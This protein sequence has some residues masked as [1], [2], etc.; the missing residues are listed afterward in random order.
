MRC[1]SP[2]KTAEEWERR[3]KDSVKTI[4][5]TGASASPR[6]ASAWERPSSPSGSG[7]PSR[8]R[9]VGTTSMFWDKVSTRRPGSAGCWSSQGTSVTVR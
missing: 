2:S 9:T 7:A 5:Q 6:A 8:S 1:Q 4:G 3:K